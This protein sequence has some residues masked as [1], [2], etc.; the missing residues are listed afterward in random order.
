MA[1][2][3]ARELRNEELLKNVSDKMPGW[4]NWWAK[5]NEIKNILESENLSKKYYCEF[6]DYLT[7]GIGELND[8]YCIYTG[9]AIKDSIRSRL[10]WHICQ[11]HTLSLV[12]S[13][14]LSTFR[15]SISSLI[16]GN[17][18][19]EYNTNLFIDKLKIEYYSIEYTIGN[20][21]A[22]YFLDKNEKNIMANNFL[23]LNIQ[24]NKKKE[25]QEFLS[26]LKKARKNSKQK[27]IKDQTQ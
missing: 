10:D 25:L 12:K 17:Q 16:S 2:I 18:M 26:D 23:I 5:D 8:Y 24:G 21:K 14:F 1:I 11:T 22:K 4:Y 13:G 27:A 9:V 20:E 6:K 15:Q 19:D 7:K 3:E